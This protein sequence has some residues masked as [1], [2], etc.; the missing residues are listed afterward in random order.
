MQTG[1]SLAVCSCSLTLQLNPIERFWAAFK[2]F[3]RDNTAW[4]AEGLRAL[5]VKGASEGVPEDQVGRYFRA[6]WRT[7]DAYE[8]GMPYRL[9]KFATRKYKGHRGIPSEASLEDMLAELTALEAK[10][11]GMPVPKPLALVFR[12]SAPKRAKSAPVVYW[13]QC[14]VMVDLSTG[15]EVRCGKWRS[16]TEEVHAKHATSSDKDEAFRCDANPHTKCVDECDSCG[17]TFCRGNC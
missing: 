7:A 13:V 14:G 3:A 17:G 2:F 5:L 4:S 6:C 16:V 8:K 15:R 1:D 12:N 11:R 10:K 9:A